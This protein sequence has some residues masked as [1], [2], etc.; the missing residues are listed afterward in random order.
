MAFLFDN[1]LK[2]S[3]PLLLIIIRVTCVC[4]DDLKIKCDGKR[5][6]ETFG[7]YIGV[8]IK[9]R[10]PRPRALHSVC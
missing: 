4:C 2:V 6:D 5:E 9:F 1:Q 7:I 8:L 3:L 10:S